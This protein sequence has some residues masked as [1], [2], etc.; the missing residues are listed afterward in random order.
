MFDIGTIIQ[1]NLDNNKFILW[2]YSRS[3]E[4]CFLSA[5]AKDESLDA[6]PESEQQSEEESEQEASAV[7][8][9]L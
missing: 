9:E 6:E 4:I 3:T 8:D 1:I 7:K 5:I 2:F